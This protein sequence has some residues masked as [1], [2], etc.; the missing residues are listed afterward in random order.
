M[1]KETNSLETNH[2]KMKTQIK[3]NDVANVVGSILTT[4]I[5]SSIVAAIV[6]ACAN[7]EKTRKL[8]EDRVAITSEEALKVRANMLKQ[9]SSEKSLTK[10]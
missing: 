2:D 6:V 4:A 5:G 10:V 8:G 1:K 3:D 9:K 7:G